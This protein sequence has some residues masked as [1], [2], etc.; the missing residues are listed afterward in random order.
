MELLANI[1]VDDLE[2]A[3]EF[4][5]RALG[6]KVGR[7]LDA[8]AVGR[9]GGC[10]LAH[11]SAG[12]ESGTV[13]SPKVQ[14]TRT[15]QRHWTPVRLDFVVEDVEAAARRAQAAGATL[16]AEAETFEWGRI[17]LMADP[18]AHGFLPASVHRPWLR[19]DR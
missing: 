19:P 11:F 13:P 8:F 2:R 3:V 15:Y 18:F 10:V 1:D 9:N 6:L 4:Y 17:A 5:S 14:T 7:R 16:E 12:K